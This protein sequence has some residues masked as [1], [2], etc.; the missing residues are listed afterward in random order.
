MRRKKY[1]LVNP[2][3]FLAKVCAVVGTYVIRIF[4]AGTFMINYAHLSQKIGWLRSLVWRSG[5]CWR[6]VLSLISELASV[7]TCPVMTGS[8]ERSVIPLNYGFSRFCV[9]V[10]VATRDI[11]NSW[12][13][14]THS[15]LA[16]LTPLIYKER[17]R[18]ER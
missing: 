10:A 14:G 8:T 5:N 17:C 13:A 4:L 9:L 15:L 18:E 11:V 7:G 2:R 3:R 6:T 1:N 16:M 12:A